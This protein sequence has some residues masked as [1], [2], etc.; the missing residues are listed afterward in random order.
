MR[1]AWLAATRR[2]CARGGGPLR[3]TGSGAKH[4]CT[5]AEG[6]AGVTT[7]CD[8]LRRRTSSSSRCKWGSCTCGNN[9]CS[10]S[11]SLNRYSSLGPDGPAHGGR[12]RQRRRATGQ[13]E[14]TL[15]SE[16]VSRVGAQ[17]RP[18]THRR[19]SRSGLQ[20]HRAAPARGSWG[21]S[22]CQC[23]RAPARGTMPQARAERTSASRPRSEALPDAQ[24]GAGLTLCTA[25]TSAF[26]CS[27]TSTWPTV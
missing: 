27:Y 7:A 10:A 9:V 20:W 23:T 12:T 4:W 8:Y 11:H 14:Q 24:R 22:A 25:G 17:R 19:T 18:R 6:S 21:C 16:S 2:H 3:C 15:L 1:W 26:G 13:L 5:V